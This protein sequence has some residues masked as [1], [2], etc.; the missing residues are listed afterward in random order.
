[1]S[2]DGDVAAFEVLVNRYRERAYFVAYGYLHNRE[3]AL[4]AVQDAFLRAFKAIKTFDLERQFYPWMYKILKNLCFS[5]LRKRY[6]K[7]EYSIDAREEGEQPWELP[8]FTM[9]PEVEVHRG[10][11]RSRLKKAIS[12]LRPNDREIIV[13]QH[14]QGCSYQEIAEILGIPIGTVMSRLFHA[15]RRLREKI[16]DYLNP[17]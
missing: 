12:E 9:N 6:R 13:L 4:D 10:E 1:M 16:E 3:D 14:F 11:L 17:Q 2:Q 7:R 15:R 5:K 8:D